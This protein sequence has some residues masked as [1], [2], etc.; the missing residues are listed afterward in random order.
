[1]LVYFIAMS[2]PTSEGQQ[3]GG[4]LLA[5][6]PM[7]LIFLILYLLILRPQAKRQKMHQ[8]MVDA[9]GKGDKIVTTGG[10]HGTVLKVNEKEGT[11]LIKIADDVKIEIDRA[12]LS[13]RF[14]AD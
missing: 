13:R 8:Q 4:G 6:L 1:M 11:L 9:I 10:I 3:G 5:F 12:A 2:A 14:Q 7:I